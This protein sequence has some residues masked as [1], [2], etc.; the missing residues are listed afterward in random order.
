MIDEA[1]WL[2]NWR[3]QDVDGRKYVRYGIVVSL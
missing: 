2:R 1:T 3:D